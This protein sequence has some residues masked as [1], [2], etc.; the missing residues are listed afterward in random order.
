M[1]VSRLFINGPIFSRKGD[2]SI[3]PDVDDPVFRQRGVS[4]VGEE[5]EGHGRQT[6]V[7]NMH[8]LLRHLAYSDG[9]EVACFITSTHHVQLNTQTLVSNH[10]TGSIL[11]GNLP[12]FHSHVP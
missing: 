6:V 7:H 12:S 1:R 10:L 8:P 4:E 2:V 5:A 3:W 9:P 11:S